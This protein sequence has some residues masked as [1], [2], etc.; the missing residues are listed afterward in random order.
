MRKI[1]FFFGLFLFSVFSFGQHQYFNV[2]NAK[3]LKKE[4]SNSLLKQKS[5]KTPGDV[6]WSDDF[7]DPSNWVITN[8]LG[9]GQDW[10]ITTDGPIGSYSAPMGAM[11]S[12]SGGNFA[13]YDSDG[14]GTSGG[15]QD[16]YISSSQSI[17]LS[18]Y[19]NVALKFEQYYRRWE[20]QTYIGISIDNVN[21]DY[22]EVNA[23]LSQSVTVYDTIE[24]NISSYAA[25]QPT[26]WIR[27]RYHGVWDYAWMI[28]DV[29][30]VEGANNELMIGDIIP[31]F[32]G[33]G[34]YSMIPSVQADNA[35]FDISFGAFVSNNGIFDQ[36]NVKLNVN[37][38]NGLYDEISDSA[39]TCL[40][41]N[42]DSLAISSVFDPPTAVDE[43]N[44][45]FTVS[46]DSI[47]QLPEN[48]SDSISFNITD[49][50]YARDKYHSGTNGP[51]MYV[52]GQDGDAVG[53]QLWV[54]NTAEVSSVSVYIT[55]GSAPGTTIIG[56]LLKNDS[57]TYEVYNEILTSQEHTIMPNEP[58][59]WIT[60]D[61]EKDGASENLEGGYFYIVAV[62]CYWAND[63]LYFGGDATGPHDFP[64]SSRVRVGGA[65]NDDWGWGGGSVPMI[66]LNFEGY[67]AALAIT[68]VPDTLVVEGENYSYLMETAYGNGTL[69]FDIVDAPAWLS[70]TDNGDGTASFSGT[71][72]NE[73]AGNY[74]AA[75]SV[76]D[77]IDTLVQE[78][79]LWVEDNGLSIAITENEISIYPNPST[80]IVYFKN[81]E[82]AS[83]FI[84]DINGKLVR[85]YKNVSTNNQID[86]SDLMQGNYTAKIINNGRT[87]TT[88][89]NLF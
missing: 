21:W 6:I 26:V 7:S 76:T 22:I 75:F 63:D 62:E 28:D 31:V 81:V 69:T 1:L 8:N 23:N 84:Y 14:I 38:N 5:S 85:T 54:Y 52:D 74:D 67:Q 65:G 11:E 35:E 49:Y 9:N 12:S 53:V 46:Q 83:I 72:G 77:G 78:F 86:L 64:Y 87:Y 36:T 30:I 2:G 24:V 44:M 29:A 66:R 47:D 3:Q 51:Q 45:V 73:D 20:E 80:G 39:I 79:T 34:F 40:V 70:V 33:L 41:D 18:S 56:K 37:V 25:Y 27:F 58:G 61:L 50:V 13:M 48:N 55:S 19:S 17:D 57:T 59:S 43:Y 71:P 60:L 32:D 88:K 82:N 10:I 15:L 4:Y 42:T 68:T 89:L 16:A